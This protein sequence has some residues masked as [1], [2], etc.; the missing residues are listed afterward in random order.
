MYKN[1]HNPVLIKEIVNNLNIRKK[2]TYVDATFGFG[3]YTRNILEQADCRVISLDRDPDV[4]CFAKEFKK[5]YKDRFEFILTKFSN[6]K[7]AIEK[8]GIKI[9]SGGLVADLGMSTMQVENV[10]RGFS[11]LRDGPLDMRMSKTGISAK[12]II[13]SYG[14]DELSKIFWMYGEEKKSRQLASK[15]VNVRKIKTIS[16]TF[17][18]IEIINKI[19][20]K[21]TKDRIHPATRVFQALRIYV[22]NELKEL[23][24]LIKNAK[25]IL[26]P[27]ARL[28][29]VSFHSLEDRIVKISFNELTG[30]NSN[31]NRHLP[32][33]NHRKNVTFKKITKK[34]I[35]PKKEEI[36]ENKK[37]RSARLRVLEKVSFNQL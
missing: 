16:T 2:L 23:E 36:E 21:S 37:A 33:F 35:K 1:L 8:K 15:I 17:E 19:V 5:T 26:S 13:N 9:I 12:D 7:S 29:I 6:I 22:N 32:F 24:Q 3:G 28:A 18:L 14:R 31:N 4:K 30:K 20:K 25:N 27:G 11:F 34:A 10:L